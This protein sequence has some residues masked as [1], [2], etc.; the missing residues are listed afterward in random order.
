MKL[1]YNLHIFELFLSSTFKQQ[2][3]IIQMRI[4]DHLLGSLARRLVVHGHAQHHVTEVLR[5]IAD[6]VVAYHAQ[7]QHTA[8]ASVSDFL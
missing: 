1:H 8:A 7:L 2:I 4:F 5:S 3:S 6:G